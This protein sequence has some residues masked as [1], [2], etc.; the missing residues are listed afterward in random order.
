MLS[1]SSRLSKFQWI[2]LGTS[3]PDFP[4]LCSTIFPSNIPSLSHIILPLIIK[5]MISSHRCL[6]FR[7]FHSY[8]HDFPTMSYFSI[9]RDSYNHSHPSTHLARHLGHSIA[10]LGSENH[11]LHQRAGGGPAGQS[12]HPAGAKIHG[13]HGVHR[14]T[15]IPQTISGWWF[16]WDYEWGMGTN[17]A[18]VSTVLG[19]PFEF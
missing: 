14:W 11:R 3:S 1:P 12:S 5:I 7:K 9:H 10:R 15:T 19:P 8:L 17:A 13:I 18:L 4:S 2:A 16:G 6:I